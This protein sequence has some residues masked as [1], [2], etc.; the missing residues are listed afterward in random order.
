M[1]KLWQDV[2]WKQFGAT[3]DMLGNALQACPNELWEARMWNETDAHPDSS[4]FWY[5]A[6]HTLFWLDLYLT[7]SIDGFVPPAPYTLDELDPRG[8]LPETV[9]TR[10]ELLTYLAHCRRKCQVILANITEEKLHQL[11]KFSWSQADLN[12]AELLLDNMRHVQEHCAQLHLFLG[13]QAGIPSKW[14][15]RAREH[16]VN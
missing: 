15:A 3:I 16:T 9:Y 13:Q 5:I 6:F 7:G 2:L 11:C 14:V 1:D 4:Q 8:L 10:H 12:Y